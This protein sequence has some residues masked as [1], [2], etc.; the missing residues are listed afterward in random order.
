MNQKFETA[1]RILRL[2]EILIALR[3]IIIETRYRGKKVYQVTLVI[4]GT[5]G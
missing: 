3:L 5:F 4:K 2:F 1:E